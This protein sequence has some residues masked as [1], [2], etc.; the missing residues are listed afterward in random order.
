MT[1][2]WEFAW[3]HRRRLVRSLPSEDV[4]EASVLRLWRLIAHP[5]LEAASPW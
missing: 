5:E 2:D 3:H 4:A 1:M